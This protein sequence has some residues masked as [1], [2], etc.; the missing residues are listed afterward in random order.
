M[1]VLIRSLFLASGAC[2]ALVVFP[3]NAA[4]QQ[5]VFVDGIVE[6]T[7]AL[8]GTLGDEGPRI[9]PTL[10][11]LRT[12]LAEW[13]RTIRTFEERVASGLTTIS[14]QEASDLRMTLARIYAER[15]R[16]ADAIRQLDAASSLAPGRSDVLVLRGLV[17]DA[18]VKSK[19]ADEA[20]RT[21][22]MIDSHDPV[23]AYSVVRHSATTPGQEDLER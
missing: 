16:P 6:L 14:T 15:G 1:G 5:A 3:E 20:F 18:D 23:A 10:D 17:L 4:A 21:A 13:D 8:E 12:A 19:E 9:A 2:V 11:R 7:T 22:W